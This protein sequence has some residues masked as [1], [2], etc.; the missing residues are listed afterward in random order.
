METTKLSTLHCKQYLRENEEK[1]EVRE[2]HSWPSRLLH[3][4]EHNKALC[5]FDDVEMLAFSEAVAG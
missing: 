1:K 4:E 3:Q 2:G 5:P